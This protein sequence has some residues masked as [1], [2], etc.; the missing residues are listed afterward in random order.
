LLLPLSALRSKSA[1]PIAA[2]CR[3]SL[4]PMFLVSSRSCS[5]LFFFLFFWFLMYM[6]FI[7]AY[8]RSA[9]EGKMR[10]PWISLS[11]SLDLRFTWLNSPTIH[12]P[13]TVPFFSVSGNHG[14]RLLDFP[15]LTSPPLPHLCVCLV[16]R[17]SFNWIISQ[18]RG[19][20]SQILMWLLLPCP[21]LHASQHKPRPLRAIHQTRPTL[22]AVPLFTAFPVSYMLIRKKNSLTH[23]HLHRCAR[24]GFTPL[25]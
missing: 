16:R 22:V 11:K 4:N 14:L 2:T 15:F 7:D 12:I 9:L 19:S 21:E 24:P 20:H 6:Y 17:L 25:P 1:K 8:N 10:Q 5:F 23:N 3:P 13:R 18:M